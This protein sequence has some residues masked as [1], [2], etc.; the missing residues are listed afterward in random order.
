V[1]DI[2]YST[3]ES[4]MRGGMHGPIIF[5]GDPKNSRLVIKQSNGDHPGQLTSTQLSSVKEWIARDAPEK[6]CRK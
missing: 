2:S 6:A 1:A 5:P 4:A 3:Y